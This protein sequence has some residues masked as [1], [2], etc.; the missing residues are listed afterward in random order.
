YTYPKFYDNDHIISCIRNEQG[1]M[2]L[3]MIGLQTGETVNLL[4]WSYEVKGFPVL[5]GDT[6]YFSAA[7]GYQDDIFAVDIKTRRLFKLTDEPLGAY[8]PAISSEGRLVWSS[9]TAAGF[10]LKEK[11]LEAAD[12]QPVTTTGTVNAPDLYLSTALHQT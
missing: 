1:L 4:P 8:Q 12:W 2:T 5:K 10:Q 9:F 7:N 11:R 6:A 3:A